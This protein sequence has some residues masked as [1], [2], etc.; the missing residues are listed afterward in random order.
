MTCQP[1]D[2]INES[3]II[4][5]AHTY[6]TLG[7]FRLAGHEHGNKIFVKLCLFEKQEFNAHV[8]LPQELPQRV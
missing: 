5:I 4:Y 6:V 3:N 7:D 8:V 1:S 2:D